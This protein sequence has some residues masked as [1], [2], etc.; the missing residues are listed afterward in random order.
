MTKSQ[1][2]EGAVTQKTA[3]LDELDDWKVVKKR[4]RGG[5]QVGRQSE[6]LA[7]DSRAKAEFRALLQQAET[8]TQP[9]ES[10]RTIQKAPPSE[11]TFPRRHPSRC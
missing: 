5:G 1:V 6:K 8:E 11:P 7:M 10:H 2:P 3:V 9:V 4:R